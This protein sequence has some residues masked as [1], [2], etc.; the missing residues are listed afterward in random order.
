[1]SSSALL[2]LA[3]LSPLASA[4]AVTHEVPLDSGAAD[5]PSVELGGDSYVLTTMSMNP[6]PALVLHRF[7]GE[8][9]TWSAR[10]GDTPRPRIRYGLGLLRTN[11]LPALAIVPKIPPL[12]PGSQYGAL[13]TT[14]AEIRLYAATNVTRVNPNTGEAHNQ[15]LVPE[16]QARELT[17]GVVVSPDG[18]TM[19]SLATSRRSPVVAV[20]VYGPDLAVTGQYGMNVPSGGAARRAHA[21]LDVRVDNRGQLVTVWSEGGLALLVERRDLQG[22]ASQL[23]LD[24]D[25]ARVRDVITALGTDGSVV[26]S[27]EL[28]D[29]GKDLDEVLL[30]VVEK[31]TVR[32]AVRKHVDELLAQSDKPKS[33]RQVLSS[34][35]L[36]PDGSFLV[37]I[38]PYWQTSH[39]SSSKT[40][41]FTHTTVTDHH[42][43]LQLT[44]FGRDGALRWTREIDMEQ[45]ELVGAS[46]GRL[47]M[48]QAPKEAGFALFPV[49]PAALNMVYVNGTGLHRELYSTAIRLSDGEA[50]PTLLPVDVRTRLVAISQTHRS[51]RGDLSLLTL[52]GTTGRSILVRYAQEGKAEQVPDHGRK[53]TVRKPTKRAR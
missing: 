23:R 50:T 27:A 4:Q 18:R 17:G 21:L 19:A 29:S 33:K 41:Q 48:V 31:D 53:A 30:A 25:G 9:E 44:D 3:A 47:V 45:E 11:L 20:T 14:G 28:G 5:Q 35:D 12:L 40:S 1:M 24:L 7:D 2:L 37:G 13:A 8:T 16:E 6:E 36:A 34:L 38:R 52:G 46:G 22:Q 10:L 51:P 15:L 39:T 43:D 42:G 49:G 26:L 32:F